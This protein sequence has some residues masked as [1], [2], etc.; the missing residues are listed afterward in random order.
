MNCISNKQFISN[1]HIN[2]YQLQNKDFF[3]ILTEPVSPKGR[4]RRS[5]TLAGDAGGRWC[6]GPWPLSGESVFVII[7]MQFHQLLR[8]GEAVAIC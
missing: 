8:N 7:F 1:K 5:S 6:R 2:F 4:E 3:H